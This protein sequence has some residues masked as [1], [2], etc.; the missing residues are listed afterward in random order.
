MKRI[1]SLVLAG[2]LGLGCATSASAVE[3]KASGN[4]DM[5]FGWQVQAAKG[6]TDF[7]GESFYQEAD[8]DNFKAIQRFRT[9]IDIIASESLK[10]VLFFEIGDIDW[11]QGNGSAFGGAADRSGANSG[12]ALGTDGVNIETRRAYIDWYAPGTDQ[13]LNFRIGLQ[14]LLLPGAVAGS[15]VLDDDGAAFVTSYKVNDNFALT[16]LW[17]RPWDGQERDGWG[18]DESDEMDM[19]ALIAPVTL[20]GFKITPWASYLTAG[21]DTP[22]L[23]DPETNFLFPANLRA[24]GSID[25]RRI[26]NNN[27]GLQPAGDWFVRNPYAHGYSFFD[28]AVP[29]QANPID[30]RLDP[31]IG[32]TDAWWV[33]TAFEMDLFDPFVVKA[34]IM[35]GSSSTDNAVRRYNYHAATDTYTTSISDFKT[36]GW[37][38][39]LSVDYKAE[40]GTPGI[41]G[42]YSTGDDRSD[43]RK[44]EMGRMPTVSASY[45]VG[46]FGTDRS[47]SGVMTDTQLTTSG[48]GMWGV[49]LYVKDVSFIE[50]LKHSLGVY[51]YGGTN[52]KGIIRDLRRSFSGAVPVQGSMG[53]NPD[54][55]YLV[56]GE[57]AWEVNFDHSYKIY[58]NLT[59]MVDLAYINLDLSS[60]RNVNYTDGVAAPNTRF[61]S[62]SGSNVEDAWKA[63]V[64]FKYDF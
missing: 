33:G 56:E 22:A 62:V 55:L 34:D 42:W 12:G 58:E 2:L 39:D 23:Q 16:A 35:Y 53:G 45:G 8:S 38:V 41:M 1:T 36:K 51:Y 64:G 52:D 13:K 47:Q 48:I 19:F 54:D 24:D 27:G 29:G 25:N 50:D 14:G 11:G 15:P 20:D 30:N 60:A 31:S 44:G 43:W 21:A 40:W 7:R 49:G 26:L 59:F 3:I 4:Y 46:S 28:M 18:A 57:G 17:A 9:Q 63:Q 37:L 5:A 6:S 10:G 61:T 32:G